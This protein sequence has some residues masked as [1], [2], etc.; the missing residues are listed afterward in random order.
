VRLE[1]NRFADQKYLDDWPDHYGGVKIASGPAAGLAPW[2]WQT[3]TLSLDGG[4]VCVDGVPLVY[5][6]FHAFRFVTRR[7]YD[8]GL[9]RYGRMPA[10][11]RKWLYDRYATAVLE[12]ARELSRRGTPVP[13]GPATRWGSSALHLVR[14]AGQIVRRRLPSL[15]FVNQ[16]HD[17]AGRS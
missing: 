3:R 7:V 10:T 16:R 1:A 12:A 14:L 5:Y 2:N 4:I 6:H 9:T 13:L 8:S 11:Y 15:H 17:I